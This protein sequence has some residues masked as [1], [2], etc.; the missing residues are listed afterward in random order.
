MAFI[1]RI[2]QLCDGVS[3]EQ[4]AELR[5]FLYVTSRCRRTNGDL[6]D[7]GIQLIIQE[8]TD[9]G[10][11]W[12]RILDCLQQVASSTLRPDK[13]KELL[14]TYQ[15][16][17]ANNG[18]IADGVAVLRE[19]YT[20]LYEIFVELIR[21]ANIEE[22]ELT[23]VSGGAN[24]FTPDGTTTWKKDP[25]R[26]KAQRRDARIVDAVEAGVALSL[27]G[28]G[29]V[30]ILKSRSSNR[31]G[32]A[33]DGVKD[34]LH[35]DRPTFE[36]ERT[37]ID[38]V[39]D[40]AEGTEIDV[41]QLDQFRTHASQIT[42][43][44]RSS[45]H[46]PELWESFTENTTGAAKPDSAETKPE[47]GDGSGLVEIDCGGSGDC[48]YRSIANGL[49]GH[50]ITYTPQE[51]RKKGLEYMRAN[52]DDFNYRNF[53]P[54]PNEPNYTSLDQYLAAHSATSHWGDQQNIEAIA[55]SLGINI[56]VKPSNG[57]IQ[58]S[59]S[60]IENSPTIFVNHR[61]FGHYTSLVPK[62]DQMDLFKTF[63]NN[64]ILREC[65]SNPFP[66]IDNQAMAED[67]LCQLPDDVE[68]PI[69]VLYNLCGVNESFQLQAQAKERILSQAGLENVNMRRLRRAGVREFRDSE[70]IVAANS[71]LQDVVDQ[72]G[73]HGLSLHIDADIGVEGVATSVTSEINQSMKATERAMVGQ[74][75]N[76]LNSATTKIDNT[77]DDIIP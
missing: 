55:K 23:S 14:K 20:H 11:S 24:I 2:Q 10:F 16:F 50:G 34:Q 45:D 63:V 7:V 67:I 17:I 21:E 27:V 6:M 25:N 33:N 22:H 9:Q 12:L 43:N 48:L 31:D 60:D 58:Y 1:E 30:K 35:N 57:E 51:L 69:R 29:V 4:A 13:Q 5:E 52:P 71:S 68:D 46:S 28:Y 19:Q 26:N 40:P 59:F 61:A 38:G 62:A 3:S 77:V 72:G 49:Q 73:P 18:Q 76:D 37:D 15:A 66:G 75:E 41:N 36:A 64:D 47:P 39:N 70:R 74:G 65:R 42:S 56:G 8:A 44:L 32:R 54:G 53:T